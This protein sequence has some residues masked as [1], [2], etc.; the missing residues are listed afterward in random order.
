MHL[1]PLGEGL[2]PIVLGLA[3]WGSQLPLDE[4][5]DPE[6]ARAELMALGLAAQSSPRASAGLHETYE[7][8]VGDEHF[9]IAVDDG[10]TVARS[11]ASPREPAVVVDCDIATFARL[12]WGKL[13][14]SQALR[15]GDARVAGRPADLTRAFRVLAAP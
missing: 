14:P 3:T 7:F 5:L 15:R 9:H 10:E 6:T 8:H 4:R 11:G 13:S 2:R 1:T 12:A